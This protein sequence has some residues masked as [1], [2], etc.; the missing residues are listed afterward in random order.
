MN[1]IPLWNHQGII[2][3]IDESNP[4]SPVRAPYQTDVVQIVER[5]ATT[6]ERCDV[7]E[8]FL[9]HRAQIHRMGIASGF[10]WLD[11]SFMENVELLEGRHPNDMD[12]VMFADIPKAVEQALQPQDIQMLV[13]NPWIKENYKVDFYLLPLSESPETLIEMAA[14][15]YSMWS[16][17]RSMQWKGFLSVRLESGLDQNALDLLRARRQEIQHEQ[18]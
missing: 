17:R 3:P 4:T 11:G 9:S 1:L 2:P 14:Y 13:D 16:H 15:W 6:F 12:V 8:G 10:Q 7:L 18:N 5:Y